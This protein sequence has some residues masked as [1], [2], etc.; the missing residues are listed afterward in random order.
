MA[1]ASLAGICVR[2]TYA[3]ETAGWAAQG[4]GQDWFDLMFAVPW[5]AVTAAL[6]LRG[7]ERA[8]LL[9]AGGVAY[10]FYEL[11]IYAFAIHFNAMFRLLRRARVLVL[12]AF[13]HRLVDRP[14]ADEHPISAGPRS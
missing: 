3:R 4:I 2:S 6:S 10:A 12:L 8:L 9:L 7:S 1:A 14:E 5:F 13:G 11:V